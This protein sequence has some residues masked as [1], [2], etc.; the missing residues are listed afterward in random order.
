MLEAA[1]NGHA[2]AI[3]TFNIRDS[4]VVPGEFG[5]AVLQPRDALRRRASLMDY[6]CWNIWPS[7]TIDLRST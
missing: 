1:V 2:D 5:V 6:R 4:G 7:M 3:V